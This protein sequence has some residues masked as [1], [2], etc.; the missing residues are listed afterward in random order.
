[1]FPRMHVSL[2][3]SDIKKSEAFYTFLFGVEPV[4]TKAD[5]IKYYVESLSLVISLIE[6]PDRVN[7]AFGHLGIQVETEQ[8]VLDRLSEFK[9]SEFEVREEMK[10]SCCYAIQ[11]KFW[12]ADPDGHQW[13]IYYFHEDVDFFD[14]HQNMAS[15]AADK[16]S[17]LP[18]V[19]TKCC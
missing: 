8:E 6:R 12:A 13:E 17:N 14:P 1:M 11:D 2:N 19:G 7:P 5:Y 10:T 4:K 3:V 16:S 18:E 15:Q 9:N